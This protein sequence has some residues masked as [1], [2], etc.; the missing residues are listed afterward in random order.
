MKI[1]L[2]KAAQRIEVTTQVPS[3]YE[4]LGRFPGLLRDGIDF[5]IPLEPRIA[6]NLLGR[7]RLKFPKATFDK[8]VLEY[9]NSPYKLKEIPKDF[10]FFTKPKDF[11]EIALRYLYTGGGGGLLLDPGMGKTKVILDFIALKGFKKSLIVCPLALLFVWEDEQ[12]LHRPDK[13]IYSIKTTDWEK[14]VDGIRKADIVVINYDK[15]V[16]LADRL[17]DEGF[18]FMAIDEGLIKDPSS[19]RT[20][21]LTWLGRRIKHRVIMSGTLVNNS[22]LD[23]FAPVR[24][25]EPSLVGGN[26][27]N[28]KEEYTIQ[29]GEIG[30][31][32]VVGYK[33]VPEIKSILETIS[34][35]MTKEKWLKLPPKEFIDVWVQASD[36]QRQA[37]VDLQ[38]NYIATIGG[39]TLEVQN[40]L[41]SLCKLIQ[42]SNGFVYHNSEEE[43]A[44]LDPETSVSPKVKRETY[45]FPEQ[46]KINKLIELLTGELADK[47][48]MLWYNMQGEYE[49]ISK[50]LTKAQI[51]FLSIRGGEG[52]AGDK[53]RTFN[54]NPVFRVL[55]CQARSVNYGITV[56]GKDYE[57]NDIP[58]LSRIR[59]EVFTQIFYSLN[60]SLETYLQQQDRIHRLG[61]EFD[62]RYYRLFTNLEAERHVKEKID[63]KLS[64]RGQILQDVIT[65]LGI[66]IV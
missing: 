54:R 60:F 30:K 9:S 23:V 16:A 53:V 13:S 48:S 56:L 25:L 58:V 31:K 55:L 66:R 62:C 34:I 10:K 20:K 47:R 50:A 4:K 1:T 28:F 45:F 42:I 33:K 64:I 65:S 18:D 19:K 43:L 57:E 63:E 49:L 5:F 40:P 29:V 27:H 59:P 41:T 37:Y 15:A 35:V 52:D 7:L 2:N 39:K 12:A 46:P 11:Q 17:V 32:F 14:E 24:F 22:P 44:E 3:E 36:E 21:A 26:F 6:C 8:E 61:Q 51:P 38:S